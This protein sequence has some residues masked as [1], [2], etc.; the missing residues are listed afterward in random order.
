MIS[1]RRLATAILLAVLGVA[2]LSVRLSHP[3][4][5]TDEITYMSGVLESMAQGTVFPVYGNGALFVNKPP[6]SL[7]MMRLSSEVLGPG[8]FAARLPSALAATA[9]GVVIYLFGA[10]F[11]DRKSVV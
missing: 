8:P 7:W 3:P 9:T 1:R 11:L 5:H 10:V 2:A 4:L 6:L